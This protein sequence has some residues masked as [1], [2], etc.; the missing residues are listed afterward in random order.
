M[1]KYLELIGLIPIVISIF[2]LFSISELDM[3]KHTKT[4][5]IGLI[6]SLIVFIIFY[7]IVFHLKFNR[8]VSVFFIVILWVISIHVK[9]KLI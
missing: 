7:V 4:Y 1:N 6:L 8:Y 3:K 2:L 5:C 9:Q